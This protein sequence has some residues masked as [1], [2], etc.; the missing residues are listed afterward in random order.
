MP[1]TDG[2]RVLVEGRKIAASIRER[3]FLRSKQDDEKGS[4]AS[5]HGMAK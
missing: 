5:I 1:V 4:G 3:P 2:D